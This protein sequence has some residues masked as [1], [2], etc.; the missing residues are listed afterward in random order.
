MSAASSSWPIASLSCSSDGR[1]SGTN[2]PALAALGCALGSAFRSSVLTPAM[3]VTRSLS[4]SSLTS[5]ACISPTSLRHR[6][7]VLAHE[8]LAL[9]DLVAHDQLDQLAHHRPAFAR[10]LQE[11]EV[12]DRAREQHQHAASSS[13][14]E[15]ELPALEVQRARSHQAGIGDQDL[16][17]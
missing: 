7:E 16:H 14:A 13:A 12:V 6:V 3:P 8:A 2:G 17:R 10:R 15:R 1:A 4:A 11:D 9:R 5:L